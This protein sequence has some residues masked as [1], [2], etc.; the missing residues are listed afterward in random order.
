MGGQRRYD[1]THGKDQNTQQKG[2][3]IKDQFPWEWEAQHKGPCLLR[4][5][6]HPVRNRC[7]Q[8]T[9]MRGYGISVRDIC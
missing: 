1:G 7:H 6:P 9:E 8:D 2:K 3:R 5:H 4:V